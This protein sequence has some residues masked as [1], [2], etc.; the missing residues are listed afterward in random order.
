[1]ETSRR[2]GDDG[3]NYHT[4]SLSLKKIEDFVEKTK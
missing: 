2:Y 1:M 3:E 4:K